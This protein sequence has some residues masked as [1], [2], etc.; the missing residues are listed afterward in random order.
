MNV[1]IHSN[2]T[3]MN[4]EEKIVITELEKFMERYELHH[5][6]SDVLERII[7]L[8]IAA[9]GLVAALSWDK[10]LHHLFEKLFGSSDSLFA[11]VLY[12]FVITGIAAIISVRLGKFLE[13]RRQKA[14]K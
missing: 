7:L 5:V 10:A 2:D 13:R 11:E 8:V 12:A 14:V 1:A 6:Y 4:P 3:R 9:L